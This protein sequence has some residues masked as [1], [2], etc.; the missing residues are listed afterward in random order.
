MFKVKGSYY[1][2]IKYLF[3]EFF[4]ILIKYKILFNKKL[5]NI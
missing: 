5:K 1:E 2:F 3:I 4:F